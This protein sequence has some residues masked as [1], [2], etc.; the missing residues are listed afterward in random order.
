MRE[1]A[2]EGD[3]EML[4]SL[5]SA[6]LARASCRR[7]RLE[8]PKDDDTL[9]FSD[10]PSHPEG[11]LEALGLDENGPKSHT[12]GYLHVTLAWMR[13]WS[14]ETRARIVMEKTHFWPRLVEPLEWLQPP[15]AAGPPA[16]AWQH[17]WLDFLVAH[18]D[19]RGLA[20]WVRSLPFSVG[21]YVDEHGKSCVDLDLEKL[22][23]RGLRFCTSY[24]R[25]VL[26]QQLGRR[27][28]F[29]SGDTQD[30]HALLCRL[31]LCGKLFGDGVTL[32]PSRGSEV[33]LAS[34]LPNCESDEGALSLDRLLPVGTVSPFHCFFIN[35]CI[36]NDAR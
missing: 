2:D 14:W 8:G 12:M 28:I 6:P 11:F 34:K 16:K 9:P 30:F 21:D 36:D 31:T 20:A 27:G 29:C 13:Q 10:D 23:Q 4:N 3:T 25:E 32:D 1:Q 33:T 15:V 18:Q 17:C 24:A 7:C 19:W 5:E 35:Y 26:L 22:E